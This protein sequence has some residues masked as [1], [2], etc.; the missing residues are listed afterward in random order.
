MN[1][2][3]INL[4]WDIKMKKQLPDQG[5]YSPEVEEILHKQ[6]SLLVRKGILFLA[7][8]VVLILCGTHFIKYPDRLAASVIMDT[9]SVNDSTFCMG[10]L[11]LTSAAASIVT[12][13]QQALM[14]I[15]SGP[16]GIPVEVSGKVLTILPIGYGDYCKVLIQPDT[17]INVYGY[18]GTAHIMI[19]ETSL[20]SK[21]L[22]PVLAVFRSGD[23]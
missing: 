13:G 22:N 10:E 5:K 2:L 16:E 7:I 6:P 15:Q 18:T 17:S 8:L 23:H 20:L 12:P 1:W 14:L 4:N 9:L 19:G 21:I 3:R 11:I